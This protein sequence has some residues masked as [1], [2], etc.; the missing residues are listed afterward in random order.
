MKLYLLRHAD[1]EP[2]REGLDDAE[3]ALTEKGI[4]QVKDLTK[5]IKSKEI[6][7]DFIFTSPY[8][9]AFQT[10]EIITNELGLEDRLIEEP[11]LACGSRTK[12]IRQIINAH[13][14]SKEMLCIGHEPDFGIIAGELLGLGGARPLKKAELIQIDL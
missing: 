11:P 7:F 5:K 9:R 3:R 2:K 13:Q 10:A 8:K 4:K 6:V 12:D 1:S 14:T